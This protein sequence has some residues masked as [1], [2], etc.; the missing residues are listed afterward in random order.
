MALDDNEDPITGEYMMGEH[1]GSPLPFPHL[2]FGQFIHQFY[3]G[4]GRPGCLPNLMPF[5]HSPALPLTRSAFDT[6]LCSLIIIFKSNQVQ[7]ASRIES[8]R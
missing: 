6:H 8:F 4:R 3:I 1:L 2:E 7:A 5:F